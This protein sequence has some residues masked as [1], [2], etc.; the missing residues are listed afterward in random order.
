MFDPTKI[1]REPQRVNF[2]NAFNAFM[3]NF[4]V[5]I[6]D[7]KKNYILKL[8][9]FAEKDFYNMEK[10]ANEIISNP[11]DATFV[12]KTYEREDFMACVEAAEYCGIY[13]SIADHLVAE[14]A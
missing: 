5:E 11:S 7:G 13:L 2:I 6:K 12:R 10:E 9:N 14:E 3:N 1:H 4:T 8:W